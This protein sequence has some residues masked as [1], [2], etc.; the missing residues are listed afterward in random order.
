MYWPDNIF[1]AAAPVATG[2]AALIQGFNAGMRARGISGDD[3][4]QGFEDELE[5]LGVWPAEARWPGIIATLPVGEPVRARR[6]MD[7]L[8]SAER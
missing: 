8:V 1:S 7:A 3:L 5:I 6:V 2:P 4:R